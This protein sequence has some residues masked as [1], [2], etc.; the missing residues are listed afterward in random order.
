LL[1][2]IVHVEI[3]QSPVAKDPSGFAQARSGKKK[4]GIM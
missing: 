2:G 4:A 1:F 3:D